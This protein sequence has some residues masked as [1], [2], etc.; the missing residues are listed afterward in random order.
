MVVA[1]GITSLIQNL[2][3][4]EQQPIKKNYI[5]KGKKIF[6]IQSKQNSQW[7]NKKTST[8]VGKLKHFD[9]TREGTQNS[10]CRLQPKCNTLKLS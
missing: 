5:E 9:P 2:D 6:K 1:G 4:H 8:R 7:H 3:D 10:L